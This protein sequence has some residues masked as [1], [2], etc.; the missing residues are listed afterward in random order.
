MNYGM[1]FMTLYRRQGSRPSPWKRN[2]K[3]KIAVWGGLTNSC[4]KKRRE[5]PK[6]KGE[7]RYKHLNAEFQ[8][9][10]KRDKKAFFS[11]QCKEIEEKNRMGKTRDLFKKIR[12]HFMQRWAR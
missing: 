3:S 9:I 5:K 7:E 1:R 10:P 11:D 4:E 12:E 6:R 8:R 2:A